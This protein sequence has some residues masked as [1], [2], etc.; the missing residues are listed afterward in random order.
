MS[1]D[2]SVR[3]PSFEPAAFDEP[4]SRNIENEGI[5]HQL[6]IRAPRGAEQQND[7]TAARQPLFTRKRVSM[8]HARRL[9]GLRPMMYPRCVH[10]C[11]HRNLY[12]MAASMSES[13]GCGLA[14]EPRG[15]RHV[16]LISGTRT[17]LRIQP[18]FL[19]APPQGAMPCGDLAP[20][21]STYITRRAGLRPHCGTRRRIALPAKH[22][23]SGPE[24]PLLK[25]RHVRRF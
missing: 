1:L 22:F 13:T 20:A 7:R 15:R 4:A 6:R 18:R 2:R 3:S 8:I 16:W 5:G 19:L 14:A 23:Q 11:P 21:R 24:C 25:E 12:Y 10:G 17:T 9:S